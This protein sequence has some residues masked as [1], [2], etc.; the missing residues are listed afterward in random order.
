MRQHYDDDNVVVV[1]EEDP[2]PILTF[3]VRLFIFL[4]VILFILII[5]NL[6]SFLRL[7]SDLGHMTFPEFCRKFYLFIVDCIPFLRQGTA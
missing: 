3:I 4:C 2:H 1:R 7:F 6:D 5:F